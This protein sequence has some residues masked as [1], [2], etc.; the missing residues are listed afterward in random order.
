LTESLFIA[1]WTMNPLLL[2]LVKNRRW[3]WRCSDTATRLRLVTAPEVTRSVERHLEE[4]D[5]WR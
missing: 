3:G 2:Q 1:I 5:R 4:R